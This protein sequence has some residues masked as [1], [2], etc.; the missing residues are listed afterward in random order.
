[1]D[2]SPKTRRVTIASAAAVTTAH[3]SALN[4]PLFRCHLV[5]ESA[6]A[7]SKTSEPITDPAAL[8]AAVSPLFH[9]ADREIFVALA[10][11]AR[12]RPLGTNI[13]SIGTLTASLVH[14]R[15]T[16]KFAILTGAAS[17]ALAHNHPSRAS[18]KLGTV[19]NNLPRW[20]C[21]GRPGNIQ[22]WD[23]PSQVVGNPSLL[24]VVELSALQFS[25][26]TNLMEP[27]LT[28]LA[29]CPKDGVHL[30]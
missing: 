29:G 16:F 12:N 19:L 13:V 6:A 14:P 26:L 15:E 27:T 1:M 9:G 28:P 11:D 7:S 24:L 18:F 30:S 8:V 5:R 2:R 21:S 10:L 17:L 20:G 3:E 23:C 25:S 4:I 22:V